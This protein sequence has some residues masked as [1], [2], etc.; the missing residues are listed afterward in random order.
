MKTIFSVLSHR[1]NLGV[2]Q[3]ALDE[4]KAELRSLRRVV[5]GGRVSIGRRPRHFRLHRVAHSTHL[6]GQSVYW[7]ISQITMFFL[8]ST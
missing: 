5:H 3:S 8:P 1:A 6:S 7:S 2:H 4:A